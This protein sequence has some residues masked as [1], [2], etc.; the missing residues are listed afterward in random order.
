VAFLYVEGATRPAGALAAMK[1]PSG[2]IGEEG[3]EIER[4]AV[5]PVYAD[6]LPL[7]DWLRP[8]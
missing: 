4:V 7:R 2:V 3:I 6:K 1:P 8:R 5:V